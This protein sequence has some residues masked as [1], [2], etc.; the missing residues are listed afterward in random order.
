MQETI[1]EWFEQHCVKITYDGEN[2]SAI[3]I[4]MDNKEVYCITAGHCIKN[5][6]Q[7]EKEKLSIKRELSSKLQEFTYCYKDHLVIKELDIAILKLVC[8]ESLSRVMIKDLNVGECVKNV[9]FPEY[10]EINDNQL[11]RYDMS[12]KVNKVTTENKVVIECNNPNFTYD[13]S[14]NELIPG[15]SGEGIFGMDKG[16]VYLGGIITDLLATNGAYNA[17]LGITIGKI[18]TELISNSWES[19]NPYDYSDFK[20]FDTY[21][22]LFDKPMDTV[23][24]KKKQHIYNNIKPKNIV[25][26]CGKKLIWPYGMPDINDHKLWSVWLLYLILRC[27]EDDNNIKEGRFYYIDGERGK[28]KIKLIY[29]T[30]STKLDT[31]LK[32]FIINAEEE[33]LEDG[34]LILVQ[35][36]SFPPCTQ[37]LEPARVKEIVSDIADDELED[38]QLLIDSVKDASKGISMMHI[39]NLIN[40][41]SHSLENKCNE[42]MEE[43]EVIE[44]VR[45]RLHE[46]L[47]EY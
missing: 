3:L 11:K 38:N 10:L 19:I 47:Y 2:G 21:V 20:K 31:F 43:K 15:M 12:G 36:C 23:C 14:A 22:S 25:E 7:I 29:A 4:P 32:N 33:N 37:Y 45:E 26:H 8:E 6:E 46:V 34:E 18:N 42:H 16:T 17:L 24:R 30:N 27:V 1:E 40:S 13:N 44:M 35:T 41:I 5:T 28:R 39:S 9:G